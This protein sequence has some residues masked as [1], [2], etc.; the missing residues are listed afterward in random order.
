MSGHQLKFNMGSF[1]IINFK[2]QHYLVV[3]TFHNCLG[4]VHIGRTLLVV[5]ICR[6][7]VSFG[8]AI[9]EMV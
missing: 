2:S 3:D 1:A 9:L 4:E 8:H 7:L 6:R 5:H